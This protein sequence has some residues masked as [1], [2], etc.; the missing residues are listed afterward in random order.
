MH[1]RADVKVHGEITVNS[2]EADV[3]EYLTSYDIVKPAG[4]RFNPELM[5]KVLQD[6]RAKLHKL[7]A[8]RDAAL[9]A[10]SPKPKR[11]GE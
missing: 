2:D 4:T 5:R 11:V 1:L 7:I 10:V 8:A 6:F 9:A 3:L